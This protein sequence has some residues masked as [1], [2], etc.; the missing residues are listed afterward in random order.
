MFGG[1]MKAIT[2]SYD[3]GVTQ[4]IRLIQLLNKYGLKCTFNLNSGLLGVE[5]MIQWQGK[6]ATH[7]KVKPDEVAKIYQGHEV[8]VHTVT[9]PKLRE[10]SDE[11][12]IREVEE[13]R[14]ALEALVGYEIVGMAYPGGGQNNDDRVAEV[15]KKHTNMQ[16]CRTITECPSFDVQDNL[17]RFNPTIH[18]ISNLEYAYEKAKEF[19]ALE[20]DKPQIFYIWGHSYEMDLDNNWDELERFF[21]FISNREDVFY[22]TNREVL[23]EK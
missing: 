5:R 17:Y 9:H 19:F 16:Y 13:D 15:I 11:E 23:L 8:A 20:V 6:E 21:A 22:G 12:I 1:K 14:K 7:N 4:D 2:L 3:D 10:L 18:H